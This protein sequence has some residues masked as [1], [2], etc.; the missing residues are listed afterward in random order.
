[1]NREDFLPIMGDSTPAQWHQ[2]LATLLRWVWLMLV[3]CTPPLVYAVWTAV[4]F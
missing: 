2:P 1:M 4:W 3:L